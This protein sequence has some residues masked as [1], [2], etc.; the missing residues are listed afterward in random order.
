MI[1]LSTNRFVFKSTE[2]A[3]SIAFRNRILVFGLLTSFLVY[4]LITTLPA[5]AHPEDEMC[6][7]G[8][9]MDPA[10]CRAL[11]EID[12]SGPADN[13]KLPVVLSDI[14][15][16]L[17][18]NFVF[19]VEQGVR[20]ILPGGLDHILFV[21]ALFFATTRLRPLLVQ[22]SIFTLAHSA[23]LGLAAAGLVNVPGSIVE[24][25]IAASIA[26]VALENLFFR[27]MTRWRPI[28]V[29]LFGLFHGLGFAGFF[30]DLGL[31]SDMFWSSLVGFNV[32]V[33]LGQLSVVLVAFLILHHV[34]RYGWYRRAIV[35][36]ASILIACTGAYWAIER[37]FF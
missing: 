18:G 12:R 20:H 29:F 32:G 16:S 14:D 26:L 23:T 10:L 17:A 5:F 19:Y 9:G 33:E 7:P 37:V 36:P 35:M 30:L 28:I 31:P 25:L 15:R 24:P 13:V 27:E 4:T 22:I 1:T 2:K 11:A 3:F 6:T 8:G 21:L 34:F